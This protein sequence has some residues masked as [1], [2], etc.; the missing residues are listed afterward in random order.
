MR[1]RQDFERYNDIAQFAQFAVQDLY[2]NGNTADLQRAFDLMEHWLVRNAVR[3][4]M[5]LK[6]FGL[7]RQVSWM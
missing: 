5:K 7:V 2:P 4:G 1:A 6:A 3:R